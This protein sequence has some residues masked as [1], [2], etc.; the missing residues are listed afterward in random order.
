MTNLKGVVALQLSVWDVYGTE[1][2][3][4]LALVGNFP[5]KYSFLE[6]DYS[7]VLKGMG[8]VCEKRL[9]LLFRVC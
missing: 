5:P 7:L 9:I 1:G 3:E 8:F 4:R 2:D 6:D